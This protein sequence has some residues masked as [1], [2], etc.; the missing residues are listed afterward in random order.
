MVVVSMLVNDGNKQRR[1][2]KRQLSIPMTL[3]TGKTE[4][5]V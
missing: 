5:V 4:Q 3:T 2:V 1:V